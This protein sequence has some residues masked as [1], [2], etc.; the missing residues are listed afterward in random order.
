MGVLE[1]TLNAIKQRAQASKSILQALKT[2]HDEGKRAAPARSSRNDAQI[3]GRLD[4]GS[5]FTRNGQE[6]QNVNFQL[7]KEAKDSSIKQ[8]V[9]KNGTHK[10]YAEVAVPVSDPQVAT[11]KVE[12]GKKIKL[13]DQEIAAAKERELAKRRDNMFKDLNDA[14]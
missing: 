14:L 10:K 9:K 11:E 4:W 3:G 6:Y 1:K 13:S 8:L 5:R 12:G 7:N 2:G